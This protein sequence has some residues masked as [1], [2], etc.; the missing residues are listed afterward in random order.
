MLLAAR[1]DYDGDWEKRLNDQLATLRSEMGLSYYLHD[2]RFGVRPLA[3]AI[4]VA[5]G[6]MILWRRRRGWR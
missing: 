3:V 6:G 5:L 1:R 2:T 4:I